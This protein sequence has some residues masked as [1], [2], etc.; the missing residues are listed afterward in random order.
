MTTLHGVRVGEDH[1]PACHASLQEPPMQDPLP[2]P[3][4]GA[5]GHR[6]SAAWGNLPGRKSSNVVQICFQNLD[7]LSQSPEGEGSLK[8]Q[9]LLQ[10]TTTFQVEIFAVAELNTCWDLLS[11]D[12]RLPSHMKGW[13]PLEHLTQ[14]QRLPFVY[15]PTWWHRLSS[16]QQSFSLHT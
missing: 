7:G 5:I 3:D 14:P 11:P 1:H 4:R 13:F 9:V 12:Q 10:F 2:P 16:Y 6:S 8:L 15:L